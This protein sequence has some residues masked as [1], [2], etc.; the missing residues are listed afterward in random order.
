M[1]GAILRLSSLQGKLYWRILKL[2]DLPDFEE[3]FS[4]VVK[5]K[6]PIAPEVQILTLII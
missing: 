2:S 1:L 5:R 4:V 3:P 6:E